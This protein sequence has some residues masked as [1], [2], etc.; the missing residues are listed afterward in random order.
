MGAARGWGGGR[1][2]PPDGHA[3]VAPLQAPLPLHAPRPP[4]TATYVWCTQSDS[5]WTKHP[6]QCGGGG[7][8]ACWT[9]TSKCRHAG[10]GAGGARLYAAPTAG[11]G[12]PIVAAHAR[13]A[14]YLD[15]GGGGMG[16]PTGRRVGQDDGPARRRP[17]LVHA[18]ATVG[19]EATLQALP[20]AAPLPPPSPSGRL[21]PA[22]ATPSR[23]IKPLP[24]RTRGKGGGGA[25]AHDA[26][27][28][29]RVPPRAGRGGGGPV[30]ATIKS[31]AL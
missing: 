14:H 26:A 9:P 8:G 1:A 10:R 30:T 2:G 12:P 5:V 13:G 21:P 11:G 23:R 31:S 18:R 3:A 6:W 27:W 16:A 17:G 15:G 29:R 20:Q 4:C 7:A 22:S 24:P 25:M 19:G 28:Q